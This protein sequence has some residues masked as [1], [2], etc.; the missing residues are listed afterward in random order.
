MHAIFALRDEGQAN[1]SLILRSKK[2]HSFA[3]TKATCEL[4]QVNLVGIAS[5]SFAHVY[6]RCG[7]SF[8]AAAALLAAIAN[9]VKWTNERTNIYFIYFVFIFWRSFD[10]RYCEHSCL[11]RFKR[12]RTLARWWFR[13]VFYQSKSKRAQLAQ[14]QMSW[15]LSRCFIFCSFFAAAAIDGGGG[16]ET[17]AYT[18]ENDDASAIW[19]QILLDFFIRNEPTKQRDSSNNKINKKKNSNKRNCCSGSSIHQMERNETKPQPPTFTYV[20]VQ[21]HIHT[22]IGIVCSEKKTF[23][24]CVCVC[25]HARAWYKLYPNRKCQQIL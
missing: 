1:V 22:L 8:A 3:S 5:V 24:N 7:C 6:S 16:G 25:V 18:I 4:V 10:Q 21:S 2:R 19:T 13:C 9:V 14:T 15:T 17:F 23:G 11:I 12:T 20:F